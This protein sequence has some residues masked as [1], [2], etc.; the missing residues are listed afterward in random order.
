MENRQEVARTLALHAAKLSA[1]L[2]TLSDK[3]R[4]FEDRFVEINESL[5]KILE[6]VA[7]LDPLFEVE[8]I[9]VP[10]AKL[11]SP[12]VYIPTQGDTGVTR[13]GAVWHDLVG[14]I[15]GYQTN[16]TKRPNE[17]RTIPGNAINVAY[18]VH[19]GLVGVDR[20]WL[21][22]YENA[23]LLAYVSKFPA[24]VTKL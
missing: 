21:V 18:S 13:G 10:V 24:S 19:T 16:G 17:K 4:W 22:K 20:K 5:E 9:V 3:E 1:Q 6:G 14:F 11:L 12:T 23:D 2:L 8:Q 7:T 15:G